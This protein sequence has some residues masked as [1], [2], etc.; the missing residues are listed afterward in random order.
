MLTEQ[1]Q[2]HLSL[3]QYRRAIALICLPKADTP[4]DDCAPSSA[5]PI[6]TAEGDTLGQVAALG[7]LGKPIV[8]R[9]PMPRP[10][11]SYSRV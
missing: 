5:L 11:P 7:S 6:A 3:G 10:R 4:L 8:S 9:A 1:A 2:V